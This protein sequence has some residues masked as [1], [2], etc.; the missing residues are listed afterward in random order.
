MANHKSAQ[1]SIRKAIRQTAINKNRVSRIRTFV[2][3]VEGLIS[4]GK[5]DEA[6]VALRRAEGE[7]M[8][9]AQKGVIH[10]NT[11]SRKVSRL[12]KSVKALSAA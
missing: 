10:A 12:S 2:K 4:L 7:L 6:R 3:K 9:G 1:K 5:K 8:R 11:A